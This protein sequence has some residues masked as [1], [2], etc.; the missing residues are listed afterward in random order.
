[1][2]IHQNLKIYTNDLKMTS[3][4]YVIQLNSYLGID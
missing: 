1:M 2:V 3:Y 4:I